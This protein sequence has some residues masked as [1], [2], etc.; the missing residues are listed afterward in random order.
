MARRDWDTVDQL[1]DGL[2]TSGWHGGNQVIGPAFAIAINDRF[3]VGHSPTDVARFVTET[4]ARFPGAE[5]VPTV[6]MEGLARTALGE[7]GLIDS[8]SPETA[9]QMQIMFLG[10][11]LQDRDPNEAQLEEFIAD[12][13]QTAAEHM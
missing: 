11:L 6:K 8:L 3:A 1:L 12:V 9:L 2:E 4:R 5:S 7:V 10:K 13:E